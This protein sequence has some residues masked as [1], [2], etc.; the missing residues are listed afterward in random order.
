MWVFYGFYVGPAKL[1]CGATPSVMVLLK[2]KDYTEVLQK[3]DAKLESAKHMKSEQMSR[4][5][6]DP[7]SN[8]N[9]DL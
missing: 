3:N 8:G 5:A 4:I 9:K 2:L 7:K 6:N 1:H